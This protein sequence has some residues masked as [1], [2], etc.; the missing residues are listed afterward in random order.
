M[1]HVVIVGDSYTGKTALLSNLNRIPFTETYYS[2]II[3][4]YKLIKNY[5]FYDTPGNERFRNFSTPYI[6]IADACIICYDGL[7][8]ERCNYWEKYVTQ[9]SRKKIPV[10]R[11]VTKNDLLSKNKCG[12]LHVSSKTDEVWTA[13]R[14]FL[15]EL[16]PQPKISMSVLHYLYYIFPA[17]EDVT[18]H[19]NQCRVM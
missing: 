5:V 17:A 10:L 8:S 15:K 3:P 9:I 19:L 6:Q 14:P 16:H 4:C 13:L 12:H 1:I 7:D 2:T 18:G 11:L